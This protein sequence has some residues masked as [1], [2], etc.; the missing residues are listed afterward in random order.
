MAQERKKPMVTAY[1]SPYIKE[2]IQELV[3]AGKFG[4]ES[5]LVS[6]ALTEF[7][8]KLEMETTFKKEGTKG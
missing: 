1:V 4:S 6:T 3:K 2:K 5:D 8:A 7:L